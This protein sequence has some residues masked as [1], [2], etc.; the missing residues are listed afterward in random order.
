MAHYWVT[1]RGRNG[2]TVNAPTKDEAK[3]IATAEGEVLEVHQLPYPRHPQVN[4]DGC[5]SFC[6]G[7]KECL[8]RT[9]C[10]RARACD[11]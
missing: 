9:S 4:P 6:F 1:W 8:D 7:G 5:P 10:P 2:A 3:T 11:D